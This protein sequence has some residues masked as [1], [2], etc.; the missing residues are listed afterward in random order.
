V[1]LSHRTLVCWLSV[2]FVASALFIYFTTR[3][4]QGARRVRFWDVPP[5][6]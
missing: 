6:M 4:L 2:S 1:L 5:Q 3:T